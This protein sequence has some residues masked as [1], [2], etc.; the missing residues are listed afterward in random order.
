MLVF[1][2]CE[3]DLENTF[4]CGQT[5]RWKRREDGSFAGNVLGRAVRAQVRDGALCLLGAAEEDAPFWRAYFDLDSDYAALLA[6]VMDDHLRGALRDCRGIRLLNQ[7]FFEVLCSFLLSA[8]NNMR[9]IEGIVDRFCAIMPVD[10]N[11]LHA[12]PGP[13]DVLDAGRAWVDSIGAGY[14][15]PYLYEAAERVAA[16]FDGACLRDLPYEE[17]CRRIREFGASGRRSPTACSSSPAGSARPFP[18]TP[19]WRRCSAAGTAC[20]ARAR[21]SSARP[22]RAL[23]TAG[24]SRSSTSS[25]TPCAGRRAPSRPAR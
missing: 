5:F 20:T 13:Q 14:R 8:N 4:H 25:P 2:N 9:R 22:W 1:E 21:A 12:F 11:G 16:G 10:E 15:A 19:G 6:P 23:G 3:I 7:P 18:W 17:A 24:A